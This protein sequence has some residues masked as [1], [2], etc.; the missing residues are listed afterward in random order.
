MRKVL[1]VIF[2]ATIGFRLFLGDVPSM[3]ADEI[4]DEFTLEEITVTAQKREEN[5]QKV[6]VAMEVISSE[7]INELG[8][9]DIDKIL[10][11]ISTAII[12][13]GSDGLKV[14]MRGLTDE[15]GLL[16]SIQTSTPTVAVNKDGV[17]TNRKDSGMALFDVERVEVLFGPQATLYAS[18]S[19]AGI[20]NV[21]TGA[22]KTDKY[23]LSG[24]LEYGNYGLLHTEAMMN[25]PVSESMALRAAFT[26]SV[27]DGYLHNGTDDE[28]AKSARLRALFQPNENLSLVL[29][30]EHQQSSGLGITNV[31]EFGTPNEVSNPWTSETDEVP[32]PRHSS[33]EMVY[34][35]IDWDIGFGTITIIPTYMTR[36][37]TS[38]SI[39]VSGSTTV[40]TTYEGA[41]HEKGLEA[42]IASSEYSFFKWL[43][44]FNWYEAYDGAYRWGTDGS[45]GDI[46]TDQKSLAAFGN[47][48]YPI[49]NRFRVTGG[50]R[51][52]KDEYDNVSIRWPN[53]DNPD[54]DYPSVKQAEMTY[55]DPDFKVGFE[56]DVEDNSMI[57]GDVSSSYRTQG[58]AWDETGKIF[59]SE[60]LI[61]YSFGSKN[62]FFGNKIQIN[63]ASFLY[64]YQNYLAVGYMPTINQK[65]LN[66]DGDYADTGLVDPDTGQIRNETLSQPD[67]HAKQVG[68]VDVVGLD[69]QASM[70]ITSRDMLDIS[71]SYLKTEFSKL[72]FDFY[73][74]TN[75]L[76]IPDQDY[77]GQELTFSPEWTININYSHNFF[78]ANGG[79]VTAR[80]ESRYQTSYINYFQDREVELDADYN[81]IVTFIDDIRT[82]EPYH[83][84]NFSLVYAHPDGKWTISGYV[85]NIENYAVKKSRYNIGPPRTYGAVLTVRY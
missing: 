19:P 11:N 59:P 44:G 45:W 75:E 63:I 61:A 30:G 81:P 68:D 83:L 50:L 52:T 1:M 28:D 37:Q 33:Q 34:A 3:Y 29:T 23:E 66:N 35:N 62:R 25:A 15:Q 48:T 5:Q 8:R 73:D 18:A 20:V 56:Y 55:D 60:K 64:E 84:S 6:A 77:A 4:S 79:T 16:Y 69:L 85:N 71:V 17:Y 40:T 2:M 58:M 21:I 14:S 10:M 54:A 78:L 22:P 24:L 53:R 26:T 31:V 80:C 57:Y 13:R 43:V 51:F 41:G 12:N 7:E 82:Q 65:D 46:F 76:G 72:F 70:I 9:N 47:I 42:R 27:R 39:K 32:P 67:E 38:S 49:I 74:Q 36:E